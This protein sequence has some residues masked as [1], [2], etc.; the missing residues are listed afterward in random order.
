M[1]ELSRLL[2]VAVAAV[3]AAGGATTVAVAP[4]AAESSTTPG[5]IRSIEP[6][7]AELWLPGA[8]GAQ[9]VTYWST[10]SGGRP[11]LSSGAYFVPEGTPPAGGWPV[12]AWAHGTSGLAD[13]CAPSLMG[14]AL[15]E[16]DRPYLATWLSR[17]YAVAASDYVGLGTPGPH[18]YLDVEVEAHSVVDM[19]RAARAADPAIS[20]RWAV[21]G[22]SQGGGAAIGTAR[23]AT[24]F[25]GADLDYRGAV[26]TGAPAYLENILLPLGPGVPPTALPAGLTS[27]VFYIL[28]GLRHAHPE[29]DI[30]AYLTPLGRSFVDNAEN[31]CTDE[32]HRAAEGVVLGQIFARPLAAI[33]N[34][35]EVL[36]DYMGLPET[37]YD[38]PLFLGH[39]LT[40]IDVPA[41][42]TIAYAE[43][44][45][46][47]GQ[48]VTLEVYNT[49]HSGALT[50][51][52]PDAL[53]FVDNLF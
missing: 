52:L 34:I 12:I 25:G 41:A 37:G 4:A 46:A 51:S 38:R 23:Y 48:P 49:D 13:H 6:L 18:P 21:V 11:A 45:R 10:G 35:R 9:R 27:Y 3:V 47:T 36:A 28:A 19:V 14:P 5:S 40:D 50:Q 30:D 44:L 16:R 20:T 53:S 39:G 31:Q 26:A 33:P 22:Q 29:L 42:P 8:A 17:G 2:S 43:S 15:P 1:S 7:A 24:E 32:A